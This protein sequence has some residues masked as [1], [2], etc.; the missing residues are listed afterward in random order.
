MIK[1]DRFSQKEKRVNEIANLIIQKPRTIKELSELLNVSTKTIS[2]DLD[3]LKE[4]G[5][6]KNGW[7]WSME[8]IVKPNN[9]SD[10][11]N[12]ILNIFDKISKNMGNEFY[13][14][15]HILLKNL[16]N[17]LNNPILVHL[18]SEKLSKDDTKNF[19]T[20]EEA[21][22]SKNMITCKY[23][24]FSYTIKPLRIAMFDGFWYLLLFDTKRGDVFK[25]FHLKS[26]EDIKVLDAKF[27]ILDEIDEKIKALNSVWATLK[28]PK[29]AR[30]L[31]S[32]WVVKYFKRKPLDKQQ[33]T[34]KDG[35]GS[36]EIELK[37]TNLMQIKPLVYYFLPHIKVL[38]PK[39]LADEIKSELSEY[40]SE[41]RA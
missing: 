3:E 33:I 10:E 4:Y 30:L 27:E 37:Y 2:R 5:V 7:Q 12:I 21:I 20:L 23:N 28:E 17:Q 40:L 8:E 1:L 35:D 11:E 38:S 26:I 41:I 39:E 25:K 6:T 15:A 14:K 13:S 31:L 22:K 29:T 34:G 18:D 36:V 9:L 32:P 16:T 19:H 24:G